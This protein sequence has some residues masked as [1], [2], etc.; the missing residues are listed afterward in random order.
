MSIQI[1]NFDELFFGEPAEIESRLTPLVLE[2]E[3]RENRSLQAQILSQLALAQAMQKKFELAHNTLNRADALIP[4]GDLLSSARVILERG[5]VYHQAGDSAT[6][7]SFFQQSY[8]QALRGEHTAHTINAAHMIAIVVND[9]EEKIHWNQ[10][11]LKLAQASSESKARSW[12]G[13]LYNN[14]ARS[15]IDALDFHG[16]LDSYTA[17]QAIAEERNEA[18]IV[19][20]AIWGRAVAH[21]KLGE[22]EIARR[23]QMDLLQEYTGVSQSGELPEAL[24]TLARGMVYAELVELDC[25][26][27][28]LDPQAAV[29]AREHARLAYEDLHAN[30]WF[31]RL[32]PEQLERLRRM[33]EPDRA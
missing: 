26:L 13:P 28:D 5:R 32:E 2:A 14:L 3:V 25:L 1:E 8:E 9:P 12:I 21:R 27:A 18:L 30:E 31:Q 16:A 17:C 33:A 24:L 11:A 29:S 20:G 15:Q 22:H 6:A 10:L 23:L 4:V 19:R 7:L